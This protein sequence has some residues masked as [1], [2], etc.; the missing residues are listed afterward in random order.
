MSAVSNNMAIDQQLCAH[1]QD[2]DNLS[3]LQHHATVS[4]DSLMQAEEDW[5]LAGHRCFIPM[6]HLIEH[7]CGTF[8]GAKTGSILWAGVKTLRVNPLCFRI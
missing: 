1:M 4:Q 6:Q 2:V 5:G 3:H 7:F 8:A